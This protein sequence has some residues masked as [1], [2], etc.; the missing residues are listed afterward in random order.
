M[1]VSLTSPERLAA[2]ADDERRLQALE[3]EL[4]LTGLAER[5]GYDFRHYARAS[6]TRRIRRAMVSE[7]AHSVSALQNKLL[8]DAGAAMRFVA[9]VSVHTT[10]MFR[11]P[12]V[13]K[14]IRTDVIPLLRTYPFVRIWHAGCSSG[15]EVYSLAILLEEAGVYDRCRIYATDISDAILER[16][17]QGVFPLRIMREH[18]RAYQRAGGSRDFSSYYVTDHERAVFRSSLRRQVVFSQHNLVCDS[19]FNEFQLVVCRNV[20]LYFDQTLRQRAHDLFHS[21]LSNFGIL[22]LGKKESLRFTEYDQMFQELK[23]GLRVY[24]RIR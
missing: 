22:V 14:A 7:N 8:H 16:A 12:D 9:A 13:Y 2:E 4:L 18:T 19:A 17:R 3:I 5:Y 11:D 20:L 24:R 10:A 21:S 1:A 6:L 23:S 15:E